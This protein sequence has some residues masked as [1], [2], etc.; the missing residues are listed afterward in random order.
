[1]NKMLDNLIVRR[2]Y[3]SVAE[4]DIPPVLSIVNSNVRHVDKKLSVGNNYGLGDSAQLFRWFINFNC[5]D[6]NGEN[7]AM[8]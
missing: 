8:N 4:I 5:T 2:H 6:N 7:L 1:M 3:L